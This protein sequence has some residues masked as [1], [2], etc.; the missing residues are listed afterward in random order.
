MIRIFCPIFILI[1]ANLIAQVKYSAIERKSVW[2]VRKNGDITNPVC[3][4][5]L[6]E[7]DITEAS[8]VKEAIE[9]SWEENAAINFTGWCPCEV[10][11]SYN[12]SGIRI[13][14]SSNTDERPHTKGLGKSLQGVR[15]GMVLT[16]IGMVLEGW[17][18]K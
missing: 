6:N 9:T 10:M 12:N 8:W 4:E 15:N 16:L 2:I 14:I 11:Q 17:S 3:W 7:A 5:N 13:L 18:R 1:Q